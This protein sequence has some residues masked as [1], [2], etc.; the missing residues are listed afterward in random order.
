MNYADALPLR[1]GMQLGPYEITGILG[2]GGIG[3]VFR[4]HDK[5]LHRDVAVKVLRAEAG[6]SPE[7]LR[8]FLQ[9]ARTTGA[10]N[11][12]NV[13]AIYD[14]GEFEGAPYIITE[15]L[16][17]ETLEQRLRAGPVPVRTAIAYGVQIAA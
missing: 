15:L 7:R 8:R 9:E 2:S 16:S 4:G 12:P 17:G 14:V 5:R 10:L 13:L 11:H 1:V 3:V 6:G